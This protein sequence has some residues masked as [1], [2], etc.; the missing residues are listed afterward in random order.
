LARIARDMDRTKDGHPGPKASGDQE[1][2]FL[3]QSFLEQTTQETTPTERLE[4]AKQL[5]TE[6]RA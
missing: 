5:L 3:Q 1:S 4:L 6:G 2:A